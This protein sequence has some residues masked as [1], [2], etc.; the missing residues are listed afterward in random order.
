MGDRVQVNRITG[1]GSCIDRDG[2]DRLVDV[3]MK[4]AVRSAGKTTAVRKELQNKSLPEQVSKQ[5]KKHY[6]NKYGVVKKSSK[7][8]KQQT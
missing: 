4:K 6:V 1:I 5:L 7:R 3:Y 8:D 2:N